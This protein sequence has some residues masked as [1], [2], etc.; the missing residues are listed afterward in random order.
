MP[1]IPTL[2]IHTNTLAELLDYLKS[3]RVEPQFLTI[4]T[5][6][7]T[8]LVRDSSDFLITRIAII[9]PDQKLVKE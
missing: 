2:T 6:G 7:N 4:S 1:P 9:S 3:N 8:V 5:Q